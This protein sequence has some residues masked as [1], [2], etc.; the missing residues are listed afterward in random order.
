MIL[1]HAVQ[2]LNLKNV[3]ENDKKRQKT[4]DYFV[5]RAYIKISVS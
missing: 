5:K 1:V 2:D 3:V 4:L